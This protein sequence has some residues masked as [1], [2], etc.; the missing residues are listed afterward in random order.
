MAVSGFAAT[1]CFWLR[2]K[3]ST[4]SDS[5]NRRSRRR[6]TRWLERRPASLHRRIEAWL[7][8]R[9]R[10]ASAV[11]SSSW[12][13]CTLQAH[14]VVRAHWRDRSAL[15]L[16]Y[17]LAWILVEAFLA[18]RGAEVVG[19]ALQERAM[20]RVLGV[21]A[22]ATDRINRLVSFHFSIYCSSYFYFWLRRHHA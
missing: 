10:A 11:F 19:L 2:F 7:T 8:R 21:D 13:I 16:V 1:D 6:P 22:H 12:L 15:S 9:N 17:V 5:A 3:N 14:S 18:A 4:R 20:F